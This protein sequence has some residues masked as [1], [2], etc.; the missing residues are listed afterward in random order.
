MPRYLVRFAQIDEK[1]SFRL[2]ELEAVCEINKI[3]LSY[4]PQAYTDAVL[5][6]P[7]FIS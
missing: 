5:N 3:P 6:P 4:E 2:P 1:N 7:V